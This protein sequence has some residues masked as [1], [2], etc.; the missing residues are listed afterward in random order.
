MACASTRSDGARVASAKLQA[1]AWESAPLALLRKRLQ[2]SQSERAMNY[3]KYQ[4]GNCSRVLFF[5]KDRNSLEQR[6]QANY[7]S[8]LQCSKHGQHGEC[9]VEQRNWVCDEVLLV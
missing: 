4:Q 3:D 2:C 8:R 5:T 1:R 9:Q 6:V 7:N